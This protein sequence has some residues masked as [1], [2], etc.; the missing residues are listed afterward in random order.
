L[1]ASILGFVTFGLALAGQTSA[2]SEA[3][4]FGQTATARVAAIPDGETLVLEDGRVLRLAGIDVPKRP[5]G[6]PQD[7]AG[8]I[9]EQA[10]M[11]LAEIAIGTTVSFLDRDLRDRHGRLPTAV[12]QA[13]GR[14]LQGILISRGLARVR[15]AGE[16]PPCVTEMLAGEAI[17]RN[18]GLGLW[19]R[20]EYGIRDAKAPSFDREKGLYEVVE[21]RINSVGHGS[22]MI[23]L[24]FGGNWQR[25]LSVLIAPDVATRLDETGRPPDKMAGRRIRVRGVVEIGRGPFIRISDPAQIELLGD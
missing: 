3:C 2:M 10:H 18:G 12:F 11:A 13:D 16:A 22:R 20:P 24:N 15:I 9:A 8:S 19:A 7:A 14:L 6:Q 17:A 5:L 25:D 4:H 21:G 1:R 23:F